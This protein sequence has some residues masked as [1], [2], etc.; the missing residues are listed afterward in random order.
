[1]I[2]RART[3][4]PPGIR[5]RRRLQVSHPAANDAL[6]ALAIESVVTASSGASD[7]DDAG[8]LEHVQVPRGGRPAVRKARGEPTRG[9]LASEVAQEQNDAPPH[10]VAECGKHDVDLV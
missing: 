10:F 6:K 7:R 8:A 1:M 5:G 2:R 4:W 9:K 3:R